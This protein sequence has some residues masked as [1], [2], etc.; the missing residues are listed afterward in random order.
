MDLAGDWDVAAISGMTAACLALIALFA[1]IAIFLKQRAGEDAAQAR[2]SLR[3]Y[4]AATAR[5]VSLLKDGTPLI[6]ASWHA[7]EAYRHRLPPNPTVLQVRGL[8]ADESIGLAVGTVS[9]ESPG[10]R[11][12]RNASLELLTMSEQLSGGL[13]VVST[14]GEILQ[15][16]VRDTQAMFTRQLTDPE[17][18]E[19][20]LTRN[21]RVTDADALLFALGTSLTGNTATYF[22][23]RFLS[24]TDLL[25]DF[26]STV[27]VAAAELKP[28]DLI[29]LAHRSSP[30]AEA[31]SR[32]DTIRSGLADMNGILPADVTARAAT[33]VDKIEV[34]ISKRAA[35]AGLD[36]VGSHSA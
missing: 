18:V 31:A 19:G 7:A 16:I 10:A 36:R 34:A 6:A 3:D 14:A 1:A 29:A 8:I 33:L 9:W 26:I 5:L 12:L 30:T 27:G 13:S 15:A 22:K 32:T 4:T 2:N 25:A 17:I 20:F 28:K 21:H 24:V 11:S 35:F 23:A